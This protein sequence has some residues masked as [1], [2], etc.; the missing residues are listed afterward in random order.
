ML[1]L[2][3]V[4][5]DSRGSI[6]VLVG[7]ELTTIPEI[8]IF[9]TKAGRARGGCIHPESREHLVVIEGEIIYFTDLLQKRLVPGESLTIEPNIPHYFLSITDSVVAEWG[10]QISEKQDKHEEFRAIVLAINSK[11]QK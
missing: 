2:S 5:S 10:P 1:K 4:H 8:T 3:N 6:D 9:H 7:E 11:G